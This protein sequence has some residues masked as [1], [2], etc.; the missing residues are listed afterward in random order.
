MTATHQHSTCRR[1]EYL[2]YCC[3]GRDPLTAGRPERCPARQVRADRLDQLVRDSLCDLL[4]KPETLYREYQ[5]YQDLYQGDQTQFQ[6]QFARIDTQIKRLKR[7][8]QRLV[9]AYQQEIINLQELDK[10]K[11]QL[12]RQ[13][14]A[15]EKERQRLQFQQTRCLRREQVVEDI[16]EFHQLLSDRLDALSFE[17][18]QKLARLLIEKVLVFSNGDVEIHHLLPTGGTTPDSNNG[19]STPPEPDPTQDTPFYRLCLEDRVPFP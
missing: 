16:H 12:I 13:Q 18:R 19:K 2:Y 7:Q 5:L 1:Y 14:T 11:Q 10:R 15:L 17:E 9:D 6:A 8:I 3:R 4:Q